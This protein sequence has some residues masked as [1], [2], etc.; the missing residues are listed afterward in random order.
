LAVLETLGMTDMHLFLILPLFY[1]NL[2]EIPWQHQPE[3]RNALNGFVWND[4]MAQARNLRY[5][6]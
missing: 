2:R 5:S 3:G 1:G 6:P 4:H